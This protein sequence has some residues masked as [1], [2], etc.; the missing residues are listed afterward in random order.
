MYVCVFSSKTR[1]VLS[2]TMLHFFGLLDYYLLYVQANTR[3]N[4]AL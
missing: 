3:N 1:I 4:P 2:T